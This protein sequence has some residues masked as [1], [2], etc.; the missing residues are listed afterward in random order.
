MEALFEPLFQCSP[1][2]TTSG[3]ASLYAILT[4]LDL[5]L[6]ARVGVPL[7]CCSVVFDTI[8]NAQ[9][10]EGNHNRAF[11]LARGE[12]RSLFEGFPGEIILYEELT[13]GPMPTARLIFHKN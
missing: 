10:L 13:S 2:F 8:L 4:S 12:L 5:P 7:F 3:R 9:S 6:G 1:V 11:L